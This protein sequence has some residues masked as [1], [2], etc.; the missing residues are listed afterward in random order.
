MDNANDN[1]NTVVQTVGSIGSSSTTNNS[2]NV[3]FS[4]FKNPL[5]WVVIIFVLAFLGINIFSYLSQGTQD[6]TNIFQPLINGITT[7]ISKITGNF[8]GQVVDVSAQGAKDVINTTNTA[9]NTTANALDA[10]LT[11]V[12]NVAKGQS[13][14]TPTQSPTPITATSTNS[15]VPVQNTA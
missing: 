14:S 12:Q 8:T 3:F 5:F 9:V 6:I 2:T 7:F 11:N 4:W 10:G 13:T 15:G 1:L